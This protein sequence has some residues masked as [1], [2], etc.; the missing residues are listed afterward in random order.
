[1]GIIYLMRHGE[2]LF[3]LM[4]VNQGQCDSPLTQKGINQAL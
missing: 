4:N 1:M 3:N 2:T